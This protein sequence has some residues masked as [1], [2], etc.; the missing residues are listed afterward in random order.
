MG[1]VKSVLIAATLLVASPAAAE[2]AKVDSQEEF[3]SL[4]QGKELR[5]PF[6]RLEVSREGEISG[7]G[8]AWAVTGNWT[9][10]DGYFCRDLFWGGDPLGYNCQEV[11][12]HDNRIRFTSDRGAGD[13][14]DFRLR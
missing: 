10:Q 6:V 7:M 13:S 3:I 8:A 14:A 2:F 12:A 9:W 11:R 5:R 1:R 4:I